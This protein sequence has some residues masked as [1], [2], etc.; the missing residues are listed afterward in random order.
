MLAIVF[1]VLGLVV[2]LTGLVTYLAK[3][4]QSKTPRAPIGLPFAM[5][6]GTGLGWYATTLAI[7][8]TQTVMTAIPLALTSLIS[9]ILIFLFSQ[10]KTPIGDIKVSIGDTVLPFELKDYN[11][12]AFSTEDLTGKRTLLKFYR[13]SWCP[14]CSAELKMFDELQPKLNKYGVE[15]IALS[16]DTVRQAHAHHQ[17]DAL[18]L[19]LLSD[20]Q[21]EVIRQ[22][23]VEHR[24][25]LG[26][27]SENIRTIFGIAISTNMFSYR[28]M[29]I[30]TT[31]L[32]DENGVIQ[33][34]DQSDDYRIRA[35]REKTIFALKQCFSE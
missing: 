2:S 5:L 23:G 25:A 13:G 11:G 27:E 18:E 31:I 26:W 33:W 21:L 35:S 15:V 14:Y 3:A 32:I 1:A 4:K 8:T 12:N 29:S 16:G 17:R 24:K 19:L 6:V 28:S 7:G 10:K 20:S 22:Y 30:P 9:V 34:L